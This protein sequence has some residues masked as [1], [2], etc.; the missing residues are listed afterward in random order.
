MSYE[1][2]VYIGAF[3]SGKGD[4]VGI[5][6]A[7]QSPESG[8]LTL[9]DVVAECESPEFL[10]WHPSGL[11]LYA[12]QTSADGGVT[13]FQVQPT[14]SLRRI[15]YQPSGG[16]SPCHLTVHPLGRHLLTANYDSGSISVH[17]IQ[18]NG[19]LGSVTDVVAHTGRGP[20][21]ARQS[22]SH[23]HQVRVTPDGTRVVGVDLGTDSIYQYRLDTDSGKLAAAGAPVRLAQGTGPRHLAFSPD[24]TVFVVGEL[25]STITSLSEQCIW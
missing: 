20:V 24:G 6:L 1:R 21:E 9:V 5:T 2:L 18:P 22:S 19:S 12:V 25:N 16:S 8:R 15:N 3:T 4:G 10:A 14:G 13:A 23:I 11:Y 7:R 17:P